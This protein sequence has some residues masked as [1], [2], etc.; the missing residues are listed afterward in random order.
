MKVVSKKRSRE[1]SINT[2]IIIADVHSSSKNTGATTTN[3]GTVPEDH[4][5]A[6]PRTG[7]P[8]EED[9]GRSSADVKPSPKT[10]NF[11]ARNGNEL[12][13]MKKELERE[14]ARNP[15]PTINRA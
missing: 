15:S 12:L 11:V 4:A 3:S 7:R 6:H 1:E 2:T 14:G 8:K 5:V 9:T 13:N 10:L